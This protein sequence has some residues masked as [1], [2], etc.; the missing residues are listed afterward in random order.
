VPGMTSS[1]HPLAAL[2]Q[3]RG[4][5]IAVLA[6]ACDVDPSTVH[7]W[8][9]GRSVIPSNQLRPLADTLGVPVTDL[10]PPEPQEQAA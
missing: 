1:P 7:R 8:K 6:V 9:T 5:R 2:M 4:V 10:L 3:D